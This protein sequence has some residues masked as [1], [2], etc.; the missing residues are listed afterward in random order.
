[1][2]KQLLNKK[3]FSK[4]A[5][6][7]FTL[8]IASILTVLSAPLGSRIGWW[9]YDTAMI[10]ITWAVYAGLFA[11]ALCLLGLVTARPG[12][13][14]RGL[15]YSVLG[16][17]LFIPMVLFLQSWKEAKQNLPP[18]QDITTNTEN[19][20][21]FW[22]APNSKVY[23]GFEAATF[24]DEFYPDIKP[25]ITALSPDKAFDLAIYVINKKG[26]KLWEPNRDELHVEATET[27]FWF[28]FSDDVVIHITEIDKNTS[29]IDVRSTSRFGGG[30]DGGTNANRIRRFFETF[31]S[32]AKK[33]KP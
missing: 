18:I 20:P 8:V 5:I 25:L 26:W 12:G 7:G 19:P 9:S 6:I 15:L 2:T 32:E 28:G 10:I 13:K 31:K 16:L 11:S 1:M 23:G 3:P 30:G 33:I 27:T 14:Y 22:Y 17:I 24:Q 29:R 4:L 21:S